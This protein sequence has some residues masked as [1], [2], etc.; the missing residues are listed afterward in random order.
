MNIN[1]ITKMRFYILKN[2]K[3]YY[4]SGNLKFGFYIKIHDDCSM[5]THWV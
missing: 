1:E 4:D 3:V 5:S 2:Q